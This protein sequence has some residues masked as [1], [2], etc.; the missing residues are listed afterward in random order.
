MRWGKEI[1]SC[2]DRTHNMYQIMRGR[3]L[4]VPDG[5]AKGGEPTRV[6]LDGELFGELGFLTMSSRTAAVVAETHHAVVYEYSPEVME[7]YF[8]EA[9]AKSIS[10]GAH[11]Y[12]SIAYSIWS[13]VVTGWMDE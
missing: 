12:D 2:D 7:R 5:S 1:I 11:F 8:E 9:A 6:L 10:F 3:V 13:S 4:V